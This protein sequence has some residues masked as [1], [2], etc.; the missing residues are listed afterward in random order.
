MREHYYVDRVPRSTGEH[1]IHMSG[2]PEFPK[3]FY[4]LGTFF[5]YQEALRD[6]EIYYDQVTSCVHCCRELSEDDNWSSELSHSGFPGNS[7]SGS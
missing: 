1:Q 2:C 7:E 4:H 3:L 5:T 6:A